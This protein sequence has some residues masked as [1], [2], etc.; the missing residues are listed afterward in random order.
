MSKSR[1]SQCR[2]RPTNH[3]STLGYKHLYSARTSPPT[4]HICYCMH[5]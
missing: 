1:T 4:H 5:G 3:L 2:I